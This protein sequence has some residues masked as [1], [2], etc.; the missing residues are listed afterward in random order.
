MG[1]IFGLAKLDTVTV[2]PWLATFETFLFCGFVLPWPIVAEMKPR[3]RLKSSMLFIMKGKHLSDL[4]TLTF[5]FSN[6]FVFLQLCCI[7]I[8]CNAGLAMTRSDNK[9]FF[10]LVTNQ[11][12]FGLGYPVA[13]QLMEKEKVCLVRVALVEL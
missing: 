9:S 6:G 11:C 4:S 3:Q 5:N 2:L 7:R 10:L 12:T 8:V 1:L 13:V